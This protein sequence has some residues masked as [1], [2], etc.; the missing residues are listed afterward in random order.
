[1]RFWS[2]YPVW[3]IDLTGSILMIIL[4]LL[5]LKTAYH[6]YKREPDN[7]LS[8]HL[9][10]FCMAIFAFSASRAIG[11]IIRHI[12]YFSGYSHW[13]KNLSPIS[14]SINTI[15][16]V[17]IASVT[18]FFHRMQN[19]MGRM[20]NDRQKIERSSLELL[21][22]NRDTGAVVSERTRA[23]MALRVAHEIRNPVVVIVGLL[24]GIATHAQEC[25]PYKD[26]LQKIITQAEK[27]ETLV[28]DFETM[29]PEL[30]KIITVLDINQIMDESIEV[31]LPDAERKKIGLLF[32]PTQANLVF[33]GN[34]DLLKI[35][36]IHI[37]HNA[38]N[39]CK[40]GD[41]IHASTALGKKGIMAKIEDTGP[42]IPKE[43]LEHVFEPFY[44]T[45]R[46]KTGLGLAYVRQ[47][48]KEH[49]GEVAIK[50]VEGSGTSVEITLPTHLGELD[51]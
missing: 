16:F 27:L 29:R 38:I 9:L 28:Q 13:W 48:I 8:N 14:G 51:R 21:K 31:V 11:H 17:I 33:Q 12:L 22:I 15:T 10:W 24:R 40:S 37:F 6:L 4:S 50:S 19:I 41:S 49:K 39:A 44:T 7:A 3:F 43:I 18:L 46:G 35:A 25:S 1:M 47:I 32:E 5:C 34:K 42:G 45:I 23:E 26:T 20:I 36:V 2:Y 30:E